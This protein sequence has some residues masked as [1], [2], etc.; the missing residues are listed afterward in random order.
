MRC[1]ILTHFDSVL[2]EAVNDRVVQNLSLITMSSYNVFSLFILNYMEMNDWLFVSATHTHII[3]YYTDINI[4][5]PYVVVAIFGSE[6]MSHFAR[7]QPKINTSKTTTNFIIWLIRRHTKKIIYKN[8]MNTSK[9]FK[10][11]YFV[12]GNIFQRVA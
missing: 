9:T 7:L 11:K 1:S 8:K 12:N 2:E 10:K 6:T 4:F 5:A 3:K